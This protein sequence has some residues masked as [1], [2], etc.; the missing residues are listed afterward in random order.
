MFKKIANK[1][2]KFTF[3]GSIRTAVF[4]SFTLITLLCTLLAGMSVYLRYSRQLDSAIQNENAIIAKQVNQSL[5]SYLRDMIGLASSLNYNVIKGADLE[6]GASTSQDFQTLY[7]TYTD[8]VENIVLF[9][10]SGEMLVTAPY[11]S[12]K[13]NANVTNE[14]WFTRAISETENFHFFT[15][16]TKNIFKDQTY[17]YSYVIP[18]SCSVEITRGRTTEQG[19]LL[20]MLRYGGVSELLSRVS[21]SNDGYLYLADSNGTIIYHPK[22]QQIESGYFS[23]ASLEMLELSDGSYVRR[24]DGG[25][26]TVIINTVGYTGWRVVS[27]IDRTGITLDSLQNILFV[28]VIILLIFN[29]II[30][31]NL[32]IAKRLTTPIEKLER[33]VQS[34]EKLSAGGDIYIGGSTEIRQLGQ[35]IKNMVDIMRNLADD[36]VAEHEQ[37]QKSELDALQAQINP[38]FLY[39][40]LDIIVW[41]IENGHPQDAVRAVSAL[42]KFFRI[43][44]S[45]GSNIITVEQELEHVRNYLLIQGMRYKDKFSYSIIA[46]EGTKQLSTIK[47]VVQPLV[48]NA[49]YHGMDFMDGDGA[50]IVHAELVDGCLDI[51]VTDNGLGMPQEVVDRLLISNTPISTGSGVGLKNVNDRIRLYFGDEYGVRIESMPDIGTRIT[52]HMPA[53]PFKSEADK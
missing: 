1:I 21:L 27:I 26:K 53:L 49:I 3:D 34:I 24:L 41:M 25:N 6:D 52:L 18:L 9:S 22:R 44:L 15:P 47:L 5:N 19:V 45:K 36:I 10:S 29:F 23:E 20:I 31:I 40:T 43:S 50:L 4:I 2:K 32:F 8:Y 35:T 37:L 11:G 17:G 48:E 13:K 51:T 38:H 46:D 28:A 33:S 14:E 12:L 16:T 30:I 39:N 7:S 42:A